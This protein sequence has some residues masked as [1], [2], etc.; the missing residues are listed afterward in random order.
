MR[1][2]SILLTLV[3]FT[4]GSFGQT[5]TDPVGWIV[6]DF[7]A[8]D[9]GPT[10]IQCA[11]KWTADAEH[12][13]A[14]GAGERFGLMNAMQIMRTKP[15]ML[16]LSV[17]GMGGAMFCMEA[18]GRLA[19]GHLVFFTGTAI[20]TG[21]LDFSGKY[22]ETRVVDYLMPSTYVRLRISIDPEKKTYSIKVQD[23][24]VALE[25]LRFIS[26]YAGLFAA[27]SGASFDYFQALGN[28]RKYL[29]SVW[30]VPTSNNRSA[31]W[32]PF[33]AEIPRRCILASSRHLR[34]FAVASITTSWPSLVKT[35]AAKTRAMYTWSLSSPLY[36]GTGVTTLR[37][38]S[39]CSRTSP[40]MASLAA[41][42]SVVPE[43]RLKPR[44]CRSSVPPGHQ[45]AR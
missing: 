19:M 13:T 6:D 23:R 30:K 45:A 14:A 4:S 35:I 32:A 15:Y 44:Q 25:E 33:P 36:V 29:R 16:D 22:V 2:R 7:T 24:D 5:A 40:G 38:S 10:W 27:K 18:T 3:L 9:L 28:G 20:S 42:A 26:G 31:H 8:A 37:I 11:G 21:Y 12:V 41:R 43:G 1:L 17:K 39:M 34:R